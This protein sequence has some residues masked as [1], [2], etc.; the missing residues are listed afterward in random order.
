M[1]P[2]ISLPL[3]HLSLHFISKLLPRIH[4]RLR[5]LDHQLPL[6][7]RT[8][9]WIWSIS[10]CVTT[11]H[12][13][14]SISPHPNTS[15]SP[16]LAS[17]HSSWSHPLPFWDHQEELHFFPGFKK[18]NLQPFRIKYNTH[19][20]KYPVHLCTGWLS[21]S[22]RTQATKSRNRTLLPQK[23]LTCSLSRDNHYTD[24]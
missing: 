17:S 20:V 12:T 7:Q 2:N 3:V 10:I 18:K 4:W 24:F 21:R 16:V 8:P 6:H 13:L 9:S 11:Q 15:I 5:P 14:F 19:T 23:P 1:L 22:H